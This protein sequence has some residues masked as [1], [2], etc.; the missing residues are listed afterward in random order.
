M[1]PTDLDKLCINTIRTL[2]I[3]AIQ[4]ANS[5]H[6]GLPLG[7][8]PMAYVLWQYFLRHNPQ[9]PTWADRDRF[10]LSAG[11]GSMLLYSLLHLTGYD[12]SM[13]D[14]KNFRQW[15]S[16]TAGHP[17]SFLCPG[18]ECTTGPL[19]QGA[20]NAVGMAVAERS[21]AH[22]FNRPGFELINHYTYSLVGDGDLM[23]GISAEAASFAG[24][25]KLGK[26]IY[27]YDANDISLD[28]P[29]DLTFT[30]SVG[31]RYESYGWHV[32]TITD[33]DTDLKGLH[34]AIAAAKAVSDKPSLIIV[35]TTIG[36]G[37]P[38]KQ[39]T[40]SSHGSPLGEDEIKL[41]KETLGW[42]PNHHFHIPDEALTQFRNAQSQ[43][44]QLESDWNEL[45]TR[46][47][48]EH[49][50][51]AAQWAMA[52]GNELPE[53]WDAN[54][55]SF[56]VGSK[57]A[58]RASSGKILNAVAA[59]IPWFL[60]G[61]ADLSC[62]TKTAINESADFDGQSGAGRNIRY[63]VREH[64]MG[65]IANGI[66]YHGGLRSYT[67]TFFAF[68][69]YMR[70]A[71]RLAALNSLPVIQVFT[72]DSIGLGEDGPTH[73]PVEQLASL[74]CMPNCLVLRPADA[75]ET[76]EAWKVAMQNT[77]GP[78]TLILSR[79]GLPTLEGAQRH[80]AEGTPKGAYTISEAAEGTPKAIL[81]ATGSEVALALEAQKRLAE[82]H[83]YVRVVSMPS[84]ELFAAQDAAYQ[85]SVLPKAITARVAVEAG[86]SFGWERWVGTEGEIV[87]VD[88]FGTSA[89]A[90]QIFEAYGFTPENVCAA[91]REVL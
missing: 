57:I 39:G 43:G 56:E 9:N 19:G 60:G 44:E 4:K 84:W 7:A 21:L 54:L 33:G 78:T 61:D 46:Y 88:R 71:T 25:L 1:T 8:S 89:P 12:V 64:A 2:S 85:E 74:R 23:E 13:D 37:S 59:S 81:I 6:P 36:F 18:V 65:A 38:N 24:H 63:G 83:I 82:D 62:S 69:D 29:T 40:S 11:H 49:P 3:D 30:E 76:R 90:E 5:G 86:S 47:S 91:V 17:E 48:A 20:T 15:G 42:D 77:T 79:Q 27:L 32:L 31:A 73:Q 51:L 10:V 34:D 22:Q 67:A 75:I 87:G 70:P 66:A 16:K 35:K 68:V 52:F 14:I 26:L 58:T 53:N 80:G 50:E 55:P 28:G 72:H 41:T 45:F